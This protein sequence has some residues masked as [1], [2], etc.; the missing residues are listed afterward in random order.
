MIA[1]QPNKIN[2]DGVAC[3]SKTR[4]KMKLVK[5]LLVGVFIMSLSSLSAQTTLK[6]GHVNSQQLLAAMPEMKTVDE[7]L[8]AEYSKLEKQLTDM[9]EAL[10]S[11]QTDYVTR[12]NT[13][14][15]E[16]RASIEQQIQEG[17]QKVQMFYQQSQQSLQQKEQELKTPIFNKLTAAIQEVGAENGFLYIFEEAVGVAVYKSEKSVDVS[18]LVKA[19]LGIQ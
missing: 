4:K 10:K 17:N 8:Q 3:L 7:E 12:V 15:P 6:F 9:Q 19:K 1:K 16:E 14:A 18:D 13:M 2:Q 11:I 5:V